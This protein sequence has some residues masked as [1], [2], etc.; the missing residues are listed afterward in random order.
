MGKPVPVGV[1]ADLLRRLFDALDIFAK[2]G[3]GLFTARLYWQSRNTPSHLLRG[4]VSQIWEYLDASGTAFTRVHEYRDP[5]GQVIGRP[6]PKY[7]RI[8]EI[9]LH[10]AAVES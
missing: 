1:S 3:R 5:A 7:L 9:T 4:S 8:Q 10:V 2:V 6:D